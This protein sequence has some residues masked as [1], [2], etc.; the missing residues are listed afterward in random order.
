M[1]SDAVM[2]LE[3]HNG[4]RRLYD[5]D[6]DDDVSCFFYYKILQRPRFI[7]VRQLPVMS[8]VMEASQ[9]YGRYDDGD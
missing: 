1:P 9:I 6:D 5:D 2:V 4:P 7:T 8:R 3:R